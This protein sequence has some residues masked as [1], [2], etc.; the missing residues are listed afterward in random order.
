MLD[1]VL[2]TGLVH[3]ATIAGFAITNT[4]P[5]TSMATPSSGCIRQVAEVFRAFS[6]NGSNE[7]NR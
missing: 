5:G 4:D 7:G 1:I 3:L 2:P 6:V